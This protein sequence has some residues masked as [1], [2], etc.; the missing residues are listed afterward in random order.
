MTGRFSRNFNAVAIFCITLSGCTSTFVTQ[1]SLSYNK[2]LAI[3]MQQEILLN[4]IRG[5]KHKPP[6]F[7][8]ISDL[9]GNYNRNAS[10]DSAV[11]FLNNLSVTGFNLT[12]TID[13]DLNNEVNFQN[14]NNTEF[15]GQIRSELS[16]STFRQYIDNN[17]PRDV[18]N[19]AL[20]HSIALPKNEN[21]AFWW[22]VWSRCEQFQ[23][24]NTKNGI[25]CEKLIEDREKLRTLR[26]DFVRSKNQAQSLSCKDALEQVTGKNEDGA[27]YLN[28]PRARCS[29]IAFRAFILATSLLDFDFESM[30]GPERWTPSQRTRK[31]V[32]GRTK[33][34]KVEENFSRRSTL[35]F[36]AP[37]SGSKST[38]NMLKNGTIS[39]RSP[40]DIINFLGSVIAAKHYLPAGERY[41]PT[42][43]F[44]ITFQE[45]ELFD[46]KRGRSPNSVITVSDEDGD[47]F[48]V[49]TPQY[50]QQNEALSLRFI[51]L[52]S[53]TI[54][55]ATTE[56][57][58]SSP[59]SLTLNVN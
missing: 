55:R 56:D 37:T 4:A 7:T 42:G 34:S 24:K 58:V 36:K 15:Y 28:E 50:G 52:I 19:L 12:P 23:S 40:L 30:Q 32:H 38:K 45:V 44:G 20:I 31:V 54:T 29:F 9:Q 21:K 25:R 18:V 22:R 41:S 48:S 13:G 53:D 8:G 47:T 1:G 10:I 2:S 57:S 35:V 51:A 49:A 11:P 39:L 43:R 46:V 33:A 16:G 14:R 17:W 6:S 3:N 26:S 5:S 27:L 59:Q